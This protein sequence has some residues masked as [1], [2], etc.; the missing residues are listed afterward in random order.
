MRLFFVQ[1]TGSLT[2]PLFRYVAATVHERAGL[3]YDDANRRWEQGSTSLA[4][5][6]GWNAGCAPRSGHSRI[7]RSGLKS[8]AVDFNS[9]A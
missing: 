5:A 8:S 1:W 7:C 9:T 4:V 3:G 6:K 2:R